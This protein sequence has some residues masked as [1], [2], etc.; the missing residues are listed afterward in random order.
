MEFL[1]YDSTCYLVQAS[2]VDF[3]Q[4]L[5]SYHFA[6]KHHNLVKACVSPLR[7][8][9]QADW[10]LSSVLSYVPRE[11]LRVFATKHGRPLA[12]YKDWLQ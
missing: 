11:Y 8:S 4:P 7:H 12:Q 6:E 2:D 3:G 5:E 9:L 10:L 1:S